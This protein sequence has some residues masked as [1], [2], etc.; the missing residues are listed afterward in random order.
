MQRPARGRATRIVFIVA[1]VILAGTIFYSFN[2]AMYHAQAP[3]VTT[4]APPAVEPVTPPK[5]P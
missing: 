3:S 2:G 5:T 4:T 1:V